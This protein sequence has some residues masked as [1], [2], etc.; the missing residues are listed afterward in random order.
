MLDDELAEPV[1]EQAFMTGSMAI[2]LRSDRR[3]VM[4]NLLVGIRNLEYPSVLY[5]LTTKECGQIVIARRLNS[6]N[7]LPYFDY[8]G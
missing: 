1:L 4:G 7:W 8:L 2:A 3:L 5:L 6:G